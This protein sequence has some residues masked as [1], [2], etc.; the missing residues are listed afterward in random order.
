MIDIA[1]TSS[2]PSRATI[3]LQ[4][5]E[6]PG[7][8]TAPTIRGIRD[9]AL[10]TGLGSE[11]GTRHAIY[12][13]P[14]T[15]RCS[16]RYMMHFWPAQTLCVGGNNFTQRRAS[17][18]PAT[19]QNSIQSLPAWPR[20]D[21]VWSRAYDVVPLSIRPHRQVAKWSGPAPSFEPSSAFPFATGLCVEEAK[22]TK[23]RPW[24][25]QVT[26]RR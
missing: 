4:G 18:C 6:M 1:T 11:A 2:L 20:R 17:W 10:C 22:A 9:L 19:A 13:V 24:P 14:S 23:A 21:A 8:A 25:E 3:V 7:K 5:S 26:Q 16:T 12:L 15:S